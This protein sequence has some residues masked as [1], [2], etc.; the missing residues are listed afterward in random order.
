VSYD[1]GFKRDNGLI[2]REGGSHLGA[3][4]ND[5]VIH[6]DEFWPSINRPILQTFYKS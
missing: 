3:Y 2:C 5:F 4:A 6:L 1:S